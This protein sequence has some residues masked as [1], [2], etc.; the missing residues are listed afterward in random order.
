[1]TAA[2]LELNGV[3]RFFRNGDETIAALDGIDLVIE[4]GEMVAIIGASGSGKSTLMNVLGCLDRPDSGTYSIDG[5][6]VLALDLDGLARLRR[7]HFGFVF[8]RYHLIAAL[9]AAANVELPGVYAGMPV[10]KRRQRARD[11]ISRLGLGDRLASRPN[12]LS[13]GQQQRIAIARA[14]MNGGGII[15]ADEPTGALDSRS[16]EAVLSLLKELHAEGHTVII[17]THD[18]SVAE[19]AARIIEIADGRIVADNR[20]DAMPAVSGAEVSKPRFNPILSGFTGIASAFAMSFRAMAAHKL[21]TALTSVGI[22]IGITAVV[23]VVGLGE[24][25]KLK[26][27]EEMS[28]LGSSTITISAGADMFDPN[29]SKITTLSTRDANVLAKQAYVDSVSPETT[30]NLKARLG[31]VTA[32]VQVSGVGPSFFKA[33][34]L[35]VLSGRGLSPADVEN[36][37]ASVVLSNHAARTLFKETQP[38]GRTILIDKMPATVVGVLAP[39]QARGKEL[40]VYLSHTAL[41]E[42]LMGRAPLGS[43]VVKVKDGVDTVAAERAISSLLTG[44]HGV[45]DFNIFNSDE[46]RKSIARTVAT[47]SYLIAA[48]AAVALVVGGIGV[49]NIMLI[50]VTERTREIGLRMA[51]GARRSDIMTQFMIEALAVCLVGGMLGALAALGLAT[52]VNFI[53]LPLSIVLTWP[54][55]LVAFASTLLIGLIFGYLPARNAARL[56]PVE[57]LSRE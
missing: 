9:S 29:A 33:N 27:M 14:L 31:T 18:R 6:D 45:K 20:S 46:Y 28:G 43:I 37:E 49:M 30:T 47:F 50:S 7:N 51:V 41:R 36:A 54:A 38:L 12:Q 13:G 44:L 11:L 23:A 52:L 57:A 16:G 32:D 48:L 53:G 5:T 17:V 42:R 2:R 34:G 55:V 10:E 8:Q 39:R 35:S 24:G 40:A 15:L 25:A 4:S 3:N 21:R 56:D 1:M 22:V 19:H 26:I